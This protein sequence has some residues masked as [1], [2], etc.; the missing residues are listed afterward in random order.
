M[1]IH[2]LAAIGGA[3]IAASGTGVIAARS[4][5]APSVCVVAWTAALLGLAVSLAAQTVGYGIGFDQISFRAMELGAQVV[6]PLGLALGLAEI[7]G[8]KLP[9]R[10]AARLVLG[11]VALVTIVI[12]GTDPLSPAKFSKTW[13]APSAYYQIIPNKLL[14]DLLAPLAVVFAVVSVMVTAA[15]PGKDPAWRK[16]FPPAA[17][18]GLAALLLAV[19]GLEPAAADHLGITIP[20]ASAFTPICAAAAALAWFA[21]WQAGQLR[22]DVLREEAAAED[23]DRWDSG[24][25][26]DGV[27]HTGDFE[28]LSLGSRYDDPGFRRRYA[29]SRSASEGDAGYRRA[30]RYGERPGYVGRG[31]DDDLYRDAAR[32][33]GRGRPGYDRG[34]AASS[35]GRGA[36]GY[37]R[38]DDAG[39]GRDDVSPAY[40]R[41]DEMAPE[42][43]RHGNTDAE[44]TM[45][46]ERIDW[47]PDPADPGDRRASRQAYEDDRPGSRQAYEDDRRG[48]REPYPDDRTASTQAYPDDRRRSRQPYPDTGRRSSS[49]PLAD[50]ELEAALQFAEEDRIARRK[51]AQDRQQAPEDLPSAWEERPPAPQGGPSGWEERPS[52]WEERPPAPQGGPSGWEERPSAWEERPPAPQERQPARE[53][54]QPARE[55]L[56]PAPEPLATQE[57]P[58]NRHPFGQIAIYTLLED[59]VKE[60]DR[61]TKEVVRRVR[62]EEPETLVYIFHAVPAAPMQRILYEVYSDRAAFEEHKRRSYVAKFEVDRRPYVLATNVIELG[63][64]QAKVSPMTS[65][66]DLLSDT[67]FDLLSDTGFGQ[68]G[69]GP[70]QR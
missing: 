17:L 66:S 9:A 35:A 62:A 68:P 24:R 34:E 8:K 63:L 15:R 51:L 18:V 19:P 4:V 47:R 14:E 32:S 45:R 37:D 43:W 48:S 1:H 39:Y 52:A 13:P 58:P 36:P 60:F 44:P 57:R 70:R 23:G 3:V 33:G 41:A 7:A 31:S 59:R 6:A 28:S 54:R 38:G 50:E 2:L 61:L 29:E 40:D 46:G 22:L 53:E 69:F 30:A 65:V 55:E 5:R 20:L 49:Q 11:A 67:G 16:A 25:A 42:S 21:A 10:F 64:K 27:V 12:L 56:P 26:W